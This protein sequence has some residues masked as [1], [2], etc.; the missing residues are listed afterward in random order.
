MYTNVLRGL[1]ERAAR[2]LPY[3]TLWNARIAAFCA[4]GR[5]WHVPKRLPRRARASRPAHKKSH[6]IVLWLADRAVWGNRLG[7]SSVFEQLDD[8]VQLQVAVRLAV[9]RDF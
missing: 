2:T 5:R 7:P 8:L 3:K 1:Y 4:G 6:S 9:R